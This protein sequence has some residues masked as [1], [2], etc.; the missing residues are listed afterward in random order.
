MDRLAKRGL[1]FSIIVGTL[2]VP[3]TALGALWLADTGR[4]E[5]TPTTASTA[6]S[7]TT[8]ATQ[9]LTAVDVA[10]DLQTACGPEGLQ[11][12]SLEESGR[13]TDVQQAALDALRE[14]C[15]QQGLQLPARAAA[16]PIVQTVV[17]PG[18]DE[19]TAAVVTKSRSDDDDSYEH[20]EHEEHEDE[21]E[22]D[23]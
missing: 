8:V 18:T 23:D 22:D 20:D 7:A 2:L 4:A 15:K 21:H 16:E 19:T 10:A 11:L 1:P 17:V 12:V 9:P 13:I 5:G 14:V 6:P 3:L